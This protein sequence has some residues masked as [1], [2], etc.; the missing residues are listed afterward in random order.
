MWKCPNLLDFGRR[1]ALIILAQFGAKD[2]MYAFCASG[3]FDG[4]G[5]M[6]QGAIGDG[7]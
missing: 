1:Q 5:H 7:I 2:L 6:L 4:R 3:G